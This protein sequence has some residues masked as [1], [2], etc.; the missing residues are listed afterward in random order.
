L[1]ILAAED[2]ELPLERDDISTRIIGNLVKGFQWYDDDGVLC[3]E[4]YIDENGRLNIDADVTLTQTVE[5]TTGGGSSGALT[6]HKHTQAAGT[7][8]PLEASVTAIDATPGCV[9]FV[10]ASAGINRIGTA[11]FQFYWD[12]TNNRLAVGPIGLGFGSSIAGKVHIGQLSDTGAIPV[13]KLDQ[14]DLSEQC[15]EFS[16]EATD[17]DINLW[18]VEVTGVPTF[19]WDESED[20]YSSNKGINF[21]AGDISLAS[22]LGIIHADSVVA[23]RVLRADGTRY[24]PAQLTIADVSDF[25][26]AAPSFTLTTANAAGAAATLVR[27]DASIAIF[28]ANVPGT[29]ECDDAAGVGVAAF[30][31]RRDHQHAIVC[32]IAG[33]ISPDDSAAEGSAASFSRSDHAHA[34]T[35]AAPA[36]NLTVATTNAEGDAATFARSN[37][38]HAIT[39]SASPGA[40]ASLLASDASGFL[41]LTG[42]G[43]GAAP[44]ANYPLRVYRDDAEAVESTLTVE[45]DG[46]GDA[47]IEILLSATR[48]YQIGIDNDDADSLKIAEGSDG[49]GTDALLTITSGGDVS[50]VVGDLSLPT[51][52]GII[53]ADGVAAGSILRAD[54]TRYIPATLGVDDLTSTTLADPGADRIVFWDDGASVYT[55]LVAN[56]GLEIDGTNLNCTITDSNLTTEE[57]Q[58]IVG[59]MT[60]GNTE[61]LIAVTYQDG[62]GTIDFVVDE[63]NIDH[64]ALTNFV[65]DEHVAHSGVT[66]TAGAGL[67]GGGTIAANRTFD[68]GAGTGIAVNANDVALSHLGIQSLADPG[69]DR[70]LFW[71]DSE[72]KTDWLQLANEVIITGT[73]LSVDHDACTNFVANEHIDHTAVTLTAGDGL[74]GGGDIS[75]NR[76]F[77]VVGGDGITANA[78]DVALTTPGTLTVSTVNNAAGNHLHTVT[79][80]SSP[81]AAAALLASDASG[82][83]QLT[84]LGV[85]AAPHANYPLRVYRDDAE[86]VESTLTVEQ[87][88]AGDAVIEILLTATKA[89]QI[90]IDNSDSDSLKIAEGT[91]GLGTDTLLTITSAGDITTVGSLTIADGETIG[92]AA[93]PLLTFDDTNNEL[94]LTGAEL[95]HDQGDFAADGDARRRVFVVRIAHAAMVQNNWYTLALDGVT[96]DM[97]IPADSVWHINARISG[98]TA[99]GGAGM[100]IY[101][102]TVAAT[103]EN[104]NGTTATKSSATTELVDDRGDMEAQVVSSDANDTVY[105]QVRTTAADTPSMRFAGTVGVTQVIFP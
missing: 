49:L 68:V 29:I 14:A 97:A 7:G 42:L 86:A 58:D 26:Y 77:T 89:Y 85:G 70:I 22:G 19:L 83:L 36:A 30:A 66:L 48:A 76:T 8:G 20:E 3:A 39:S 92:Q 4:L 44:H 64:D 15:I 57:V 54:G 35:C 13:L 79:S 1:G 55:W 23:G 34:I 101:T 21:T 99:G 32:A 71:D 11:P 105:I 46:A 81:G 50:V 2:I 94:N 65:A 43:V 80:S 88:G 18:T 60:A 90:G 100:D 74:T 69:G 59:A 78:N 47:V 72:T 53:H 28:D 98:T 75:A 96:E 52:K 87:D 62:D 27:S 41:Q 9:L 103:V 95:S 38:S 93:G 82:F 37:H 45:Q 24:I 5:Y 102:A 16:S 56:T 31:A 25:A 10:K 61:T 67:T 12:A 17:R 104:D 63:A 40:A 91:D 73:T 6:N 33:T 84:G 51:G